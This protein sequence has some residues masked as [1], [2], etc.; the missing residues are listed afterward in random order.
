MNVKWAEDEAK[1]GFAGPP[2]ELSWADHEEVVAQL[3]A[4]VA[5]FRQQA[6]EWQ[7]EAEK[8]RRLLP[9]LVEVLEASEAYVTA[10]FRGNADFATLSSTR[11]VANVANEVARLAILA[12]KQEDYRE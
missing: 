4:R 3:T 1:M 5:F 11:R 7:K 10:S 8:L 9:L 2:S 12:I 6:E